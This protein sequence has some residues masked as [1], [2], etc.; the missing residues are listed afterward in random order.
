MSPKNNIFL[1]MLLLGV[2]GLL[3][4]V[5]VHSPLLMLV[6]G[7]LGLALGGLVGWLGGRRY[8]LIVCGGIV[9]GTLVGWQ[10]GDRD[11]LIICA[12]SGGAICGMLAN[13]LEIFWGK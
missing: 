11:L 12:G 5:V 8:I 13:Q 3:I 9:V 6:A 7:V 2:N 4:G 1:G 10:T